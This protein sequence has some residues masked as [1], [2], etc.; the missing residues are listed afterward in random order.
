ML[1]SRYA[2]KLEHVL[3]LGDDLDEIDKILDAEGRQTR[4]RCTECLALRDEV[5]KFLDDDTLVSVDVCLACLH[6]ATA[7]LEG[8]HP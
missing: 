2:S 1:V 5:L 4:P 7:Q 8:A 3:A 6:K